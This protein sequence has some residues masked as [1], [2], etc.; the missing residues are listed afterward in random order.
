MVEICFPLF[1]HYA[2]AT[3]RYRHGQPTLI[4][5]SYRTGSVA[6]EPWR[7]TVGD[8]AVRPSEIRG[9][10]PGPRVIERA[11]ACIGRPEITWNLFTCNCEHFVRAVHGLPI[12]STQL[13][14]ALGGAVLGVAAAVAAPQATLLRILFAAPCG[15]L[16][17]MRRFARDGRDRRAHIDLGGEMD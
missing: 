1:K 12:E 3:E 8:R 7:A 15:A 17:G 9:T 13:R 2:I 16:M 10:V 14:N 4:G 11:R 5:L 6:E